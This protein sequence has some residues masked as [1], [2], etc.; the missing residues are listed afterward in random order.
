MIKVAHIVSSLKIGGA[1]RFVI[2][3][4]EV[5][6]N[7]TMQPVIIS[8]GDPGEALE[9]ECHNLNTPIFSY[10]NSLIVK[11]VKVF[12]QLKKC[13]VIH[14]HTPHAL[15]FL[16]MVLPLLNRKLVYTRHGVVPLTAPHWIKL[17]R[18]ASQYIDAITFV[19]KEGCDNFQNT[20]Q[21]QNVPSSVIDNGV[22]IQPTLRKKIVSEPLRIGSVGRMIPLKNQISLLRASSLLPLPVQERFEIHFFGDGECNASLQAYNKQQKW[23]L[24]VFFHGME[25]DRSKIYSSFDVL[26]VTSETEGLSMVIIEAMANRIPVI[27]SKVGGNPKL[28]VDGET[29]YL[30]DYNDDKKLADYLQEFVENS[31]VVN[32]LGEHAFS[33]IKE[34]FSLRATA[35][36][37]AELYEKRVK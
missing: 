9:Q 22:L 4:C 28:V 5:Q 6:K 37:Y 24:K 20:H 33:Y 35:K 14:I 16:R 19:S 15:K 23:P 17:H 21:W 10:K 32:E 34:K 36:K 11:L 1:E 12:Y 18:K 8:L 7:N 26:V 29:G 27:A 3:L 2:D 30:F 25:N 31:Q 13:H